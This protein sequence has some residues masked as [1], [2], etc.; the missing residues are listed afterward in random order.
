MATDLGTRY[1]DAFRDVQS[2]PCLLLVAAR[3]GYSYLE[4]PIGCLGE[5]RT[6]GEG[7]D[8]T[9]EIDLLDIPVSQLDQVGRCSNLLPYIAV[10]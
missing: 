4:D 1:Q 2:P 3:K 10:Y 5:D 7:V 9:P 8:L 6:E